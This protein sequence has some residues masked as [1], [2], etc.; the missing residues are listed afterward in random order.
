MKKY[1]ALIVLLFP[2]FFFMVW[3]G[4]LIHGMDQAQLVE[5]PITGYDPRDILRGHYLRYQI[6][7]RYFYRSDYPDYPYPPDERK[8][9]HR[10][11][12]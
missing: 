2:T 4:T 11:W 5:V 10:H 6:D 1:F 8:V 7:N 12:D 9:P 3:I